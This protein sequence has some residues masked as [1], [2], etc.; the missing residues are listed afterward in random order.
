MYKI[1]RIHKCKFLLYQQN[2]LP[3]NK[4]MSWPRV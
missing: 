3:K 1:P 4:T 2:V